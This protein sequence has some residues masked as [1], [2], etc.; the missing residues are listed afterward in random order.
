MSDI[1]TPYIVHPTQ[2]ELICILSLRK[3]VVISSVCDGEIRKLADCRS[4]ILQGVPDIAAKSLSNLRQ[5]LVYRLPFTFHNQLDSP[6]RQILHKTGYVKAARCVCSRIAK[7]DSLDMSAVVNLSPF[8]HRHQ[9]WR[10]LAAK[11]GKLNPNPILNIT[12]PA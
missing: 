9:P 12:V 1:S 7:A 11:Q 5:E 4:A 10:Q 2:E 3:L 8:T 6:I